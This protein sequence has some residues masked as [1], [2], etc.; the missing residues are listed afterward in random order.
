MVVVTIDHHNQPSV[1]AN[2]NHHFIPEAFLSKWHSANTTAYLNDRLVAF[3]WRHSKLCFPHR[4][5]AQVGKVAGLYAWQGVDREKRNELET[6]LFQRIDN[7]S[8]DVH[9]ILLA[10]EVAALTDKSWADWTRF[11]ASLMI[12]LPHV[13]DHYVEPA[14]AALHKVLRA[15][16]LTGAFKSFAVAHVAANEHAHARNVTLGAMAKFLESS[17]VFDSLMRADWAL[18]ELPHSRFDLVLSDTPLIVGGQFDKSFF[19]ALP[20]SPRKLFIAHNGHSVVNAIEDAPDAE[21]VKRTNLD[22]AQQAREYLFA[23]SIQQKGLA[24]KYLR[25]ASGSHAVTSS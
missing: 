6:T 25:Q 9:R 7:D 16:D 2:N 12:R 20:I 15:D 10:G 1:A 18:R 13:L 21:V 22:S 11:L 14:L 4:S 17:S 8:A 23:T 5:A 19:V 3:A 24:R